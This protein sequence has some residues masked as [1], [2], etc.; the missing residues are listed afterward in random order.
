[1]SSALWRVRDPLRQGNFLR[2]DQGIVLKV[3]AALC[4]PLVFYAEETSFDLLAVSEIPQ[5]VGDPLNHRVDLLK[6]R[7][8]FRPLPYMR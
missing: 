1:M 6:R 4:G 3:G 7:G 2:G 8:A 5:P